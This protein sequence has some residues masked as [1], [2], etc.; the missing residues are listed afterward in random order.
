MIVSMWM[1]RDVVTIAGDRS[2]S[3][4]AALMAQRH[5]RRLAVIQA[6]TSEPHL[7]GV[8]ARSDVFAAYPSEINPF[9]VTAT[10]RYRS[11][12]AVHRVMS[13]DVITTSPDT[14][15]EAAARTMLE[16]K[17]GGLPVVHESH[18]VGYISESDIFRAFVELIDATAGEVRVTF[19]AL[20]QEDT[21]A[22]VL[23]TA[24]ATHVKLV[25]IL[26][27]HHSGEP[28]CVV[29]ATGPGIDNF[30]DALWKTHHPPLSVVRT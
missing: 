11:P 22:L 26:S 5:V 23:K 24:Q 12:I 20:T 15:I 7:I 6:D 8:L 29:R 30:I 3:E 19:R 17:I 27:S 28:L 1:S 10:D 2:I 16:R 21:L 4:A 18:L 25:S 9:S 14:P 13:R